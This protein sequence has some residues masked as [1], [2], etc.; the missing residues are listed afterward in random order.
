MHAVTEQLPRQ[1]LGGHSDPEKR[2]KPVMEA[3]TTV[4]TRAAL[5]VLVCG[6]VVGHQSKMIA[7]KE[8]D[9]RDGEA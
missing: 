6:H 9:R 8:Q 3:S 7:A 1:Q 2:V 5:N 4:G